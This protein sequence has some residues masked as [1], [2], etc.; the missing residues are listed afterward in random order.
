MSAF[1]LSINNYKYVTWKEKYTDCNVKFDLLIVDKKW[2]KFFADKKISKMIKDI[3]KELTLILKKT[4]ET[5]KIFPLPDLVFDWLGY[6][7]FDDIKVV[8]IGQDPYINERIHNKKAIPEATGSAFSIPSGIK[9][10]PS[11]E[12][13]YKN[14]TKYG[15]FVFQPEYGN[16]I[17]WALQGCLLLN[18]ALTVQQGKSNSHSEMWQPLT[19][20]IIKYISDKLENVVF[21][22]WGNNALKKTSLVDAKKHKILVSSHPSPLSVKKSFGSDENGDAYPAFEDQDHFG[23]INEYLKKHKKTEIIWQVL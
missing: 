15:H 14:L 7:K 12:N 17:F 1:F 8:F 23:L 2:N 18:T 9:K 10:P 13:I 16:L 6:V 11:L 21:V 20:S 3:E 19:D 5:F 22:A 4:D